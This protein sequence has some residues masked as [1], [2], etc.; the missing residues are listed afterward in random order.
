MYVDFG[1]AITKLMLNV[2]VIS[3]LNV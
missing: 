2:C 3:L 1:E